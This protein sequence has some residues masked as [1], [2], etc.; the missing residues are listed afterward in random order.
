MTICVTVETKFP[1]GSLPACD[2]VRFISNNNKLDSIDF[3]H[4]EFKTK[5]YVKFIIVAFG[6]VSDYVY[7]DTAIVFSL[8]ILAQPQ[9]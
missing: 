7:R 8:S 2:L 3:N 1:F 4:F 6:D 5:R 9:F